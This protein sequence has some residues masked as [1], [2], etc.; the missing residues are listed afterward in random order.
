MR[1][2]RASSRVA[3]MSSTSARRFA[4]LGDPVAHS[5]SPL[6][7]TAA[8]A[9]LDLPGTYTA[10][11]CSA[12]ELPG[13]MRELAASGGGGNVTIPHKR[14][15]LG[16]LQHAAPLAVRLDAC[17]T[18]WASDGALAGD[19]TDV[20]GVRAALAALDVP[21][22]PWLILGTGGSARAVT[23]AA[24]D[25]GAP[26]HVRSRD[27]DRAAAFMTWARSLGAT[28]ADAD[29]CVVWCNATPAGLDPTGPLPPLPWPGSAARAAL[30]L[31]Y[32]ASETPWVRAARAQGLTAADGRAM[33]VGQGAAALECWWPGIVA[34]IAVMR[35]AV[36]AALG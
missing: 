23:A 6:M 8:F 27:P 24:V 12:A 17:N 25:A 1:R 9:A 5:L 16:A 3:L 4:V 36:D 31:V 18:F 11:R 30:D 15:A 7:Q 21:P 14:A 22:G 34:P 20:A 2:W 33:L 26:V 32:A 35:R 19:N 13:Q 10:I 29:G 28:G